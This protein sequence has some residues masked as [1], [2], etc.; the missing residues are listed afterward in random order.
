[1]KIEVGKFY[2]TRKG[3]KVRLYAVD[4]GGEFPNHGATLESGIWNSQTWA[5]NNMYYV[6]GETSDY[7][8]VAP[9]PDEKEVE[10]W[11]WLHSDGRTSLNPVK[12]N[13]AWTNDPSYVR[14]IGAV[15]L[16]GK[17]VEGVFE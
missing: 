2:K 1:M 13:A 4:Q 3:L 10:T 7:D 14:V 6:D 5:A 17:I 8:I 9:W 12:P 16:T 15:R 11:V